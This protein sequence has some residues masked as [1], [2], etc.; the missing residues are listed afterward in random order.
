MTS[1]REQGDAE[2]FQQTVKGQRQQK[3]SASIVT[4]SGF[5]CHPIKIQTLRSEI[6]EKRNP[7]P[8]GELN[9]RGLGSFR[10][11]QQVFGGRHLPHFIAAHNLVA[12]EREPELGLAPHAED[13][14]G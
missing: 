9:N 8:A 10:R 7:S 11:D 5:A 13:R 2:S 6:P 4:G 3:R 1:P 12:I 14:D